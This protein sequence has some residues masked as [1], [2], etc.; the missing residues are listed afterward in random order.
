MGVVDL[1]TLML[2]IE[3]EPQREDLARELHKD[4]ILD[5]CENGEKAL[6]RLQEKMPDIL[7]LDLGLPV[8]DG[9]HILRQL[10]SV[11]P[12]VIIALTTSPT[13]FT[14]QSAKDLGADLT[15]PKPCF[16][17]AIAQHIACALQYKES[18][19]LVQDPQEQAAHHMRILV[20]P[21]HRAGFQQLRVGFPLYLANPNISMTKELY[22]AIAELC[23]NGDGKQVEHTIRIA[24]QDGWDNRDETVWK[25]YFPRHTKCPSNKEFLSNLAR[26]LQ[27]G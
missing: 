1:L 23:G 19:P 24:I 8:I 14:L 10:G 5:F 25:T 6:Q 2:A 4:Y 16:P 3:S 18:I 11:R 15:L 22:P 26:V 17:R 13:G 20:L 9:L 7:V 27:E 21:E 12:A